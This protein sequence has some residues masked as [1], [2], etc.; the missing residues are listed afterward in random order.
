MTLTETNLAFYETYRPQ[1]EAF[2]IASVFEDRDER[3]LYRTVEKALNTKKVTAKT[4]TKRTKGET[5]SAAEI[6]ALVTLYC[7]AADGNTGEWVEV[8]PIFSKKFPERSENAFRM[9]FSI[10]KGYD[11]KDAREGLAGGSIALRQALLAADPI[12]FA[13]AA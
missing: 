12:R 5:W 9:Y 3:N 8:W 10:I 1:V 13:S 7:V 2:G 6:D 11:A 4:A